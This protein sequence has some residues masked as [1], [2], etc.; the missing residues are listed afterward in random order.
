MINFDSMM[1]DIE[2]KSADLMQEVNQLKDEALWAY[3]EYQ[4]LLAELGANDYNSALEAI[5]ELKAAKTS[6]VVVAPVAVSSTAVKLANTDLTF[7]DVGK[8]IAKSLSQALSKEEDVTRGKATRHHQQVPE[9]YF[10]EKYWDPTSR[11]IKTFRDIA[12][13]N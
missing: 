11:T 9:K 7:E 10:P 5:R 12:G 2:D 3:S 13:V 8:I 4:D 6:P 1:S